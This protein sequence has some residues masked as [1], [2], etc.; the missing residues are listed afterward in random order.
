MR[1]NRKFN[2][3]RTTILRRDGNSEREENV[4]NKI[5]ENDLKQELESLKTELKLMKN[6]LYDQ[7]IFDVDD[8]KNIHK[9]TSFY[10]GFPSYVTMLLCYRVLSISFITVVMGITQALSLTYWHSSDQA[11]DENVLHGTNMVLMLVRLGLFANDLAH[12]DLSH[13][14]RARIRFMRAELKPM[15]I[16]WPSKEQIK[17]FVLPPPP[18][19][20]KCFTQNWCPY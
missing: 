9:D 4:E 10:T 15:C 19:R 6:K 8:Y 18:S 13:I 17:H 3:A 7:P 14:F 2:P 5:S 12:R 20:S 11:R 1:N 16:L